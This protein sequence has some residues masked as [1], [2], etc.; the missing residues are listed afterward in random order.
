MKV[1]IAAVLAAT[2]ALAFTTVG[3]AA[4]QS[5][6]P[7]N[8]HESAAPAQVS[9]VRL[10]T[11]MLPTSAFGSDF[12][13]SEALNS[14]SKLQSSKAKHHPSSMSCNA[15]EG[16]VYIGTFGDTAGVVSR[17]SNPD[18]PSEFPNTILLG[19]QY[20][21]QFVSDSAAATF[22]SQ[23]QAKYAACETLTE[24]FINTTAE[25]D[26]LSVTKTTVSGDK[27]FVVTQREIAPGYKTLY[28]LYLYVVSGT[29]VYDLSDVSGTNDEPSTKL[30][31][32]LIHR[33]Q[34]LYP[35]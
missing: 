13:F 33:V 26:T 35:H 20:V 27:A 14:G 17:Y 30:M 28:L 25:V 6:G 1:K 11:A 34:A 22:Y 18:W 29:N 32:E 23:A 10:Q 2:T 3:S 31:K 12:T 7:A 8:Q 21:L 19:D 16:R 5:L 24:P 4:A 15:F 9:G